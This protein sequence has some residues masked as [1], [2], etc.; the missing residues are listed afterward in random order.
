MDWRFDG[1]IAGI[2]TAMGL[3]VVVGR[4]P[5]SPFGPFTDV[6]VERPDGHRIL[7]APTHAIAEFVAQTYFF[8]DVLVVPVTMAV[9]Q[10]RRLRPAD[11]RG[12][13][14]RRLRAV[15]AERAPH[16]ERAP[17]IRW[18]VDAGPIA[19]SFDVGARSALGWLLWAVP[20]EI[21]TAPWWVATVD[22]VAQLVLPGVRTRGS[23]GNGRRESYA[24]LD[25]HRIW[26]ASVVWQGE[27]QGG[28]APVDP[29]VRFGFGSTPRE[30]SLA[31]VRTLVRD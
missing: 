31:R 18:R 1:Y 25:L 27:D 5:R 10:E 16:G 22:T 23:A 20:R 4:W 29:P 12:V 19:V 17:C 13:W 24:A 28:L 15:L 2:G 14:S 21:A 11:V 6:M 7:I 8:D 26:Q 9:T 3:R 30:P